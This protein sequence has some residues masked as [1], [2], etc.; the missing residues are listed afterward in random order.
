METR[1]HPAR[2]PSPS[3]RT[4]GARAA[5]RGSHAGNQARRPHQGLRQTENR[6]RHGQSTRRDA[7]PRCQRRVRVGGAPL[8]SGASPRRNGRNGGRA[9]PGPGRAH[10]HGAS[11]YS[12]AKFSSSTA[13]VSAGYAPARRAICA[14]ALAPRPQAG[15]STPP[16]ADAVL[17]KISRDFEPATYPLSAPRR[18]RLHGSPRCPPTTEKMRWYAPPLSSRRR[19]GSRLRPPSPARRLLRCPGAAHQ[20]G[21]GPR[22]DQPL[23]QNPLPHRPG[24][25]RQLHS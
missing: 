20:G 4:C 19:R 9:D 11:H 25:L 2:R 23:R 24:P 14:L 6:P 10:A 7:G 17:A 21:Q 5:D 22:T 3:S 13:I 1:A 12:A 8:T 15:A 18:F 16:A